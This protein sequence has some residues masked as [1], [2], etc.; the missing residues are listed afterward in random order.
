LNG[1][2]GD[3]GVGAG[4]SGEGLKALEAIKFVGDARYVG[5][6]GPNEDKLVVVDAHVVLLELST[7]RPKVAVRVGARCSGSARELKLPLVTFLDAFNDF[8]IARLFKVN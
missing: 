5:A 3:C 6:L 4:L 1:P 7:A 8:E 2:L